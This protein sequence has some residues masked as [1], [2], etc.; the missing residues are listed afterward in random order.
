[1]KLTAAMRKYDSLVTEWYTD[2]L[3]Y[4]LPWV[5]LTAKNFDYA[6][7]MRYQLWA[8]REGLTD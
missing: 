3:F 5:K 8:V 2:D 7:Y 4:H 1:M 6:I